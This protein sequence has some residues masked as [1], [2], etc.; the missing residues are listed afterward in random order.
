MRRYFAGMTEPV[1]KTLSTVAGVLVAKAFIFAGM[2]RAGTTQQ[3]VV[4]FQASS[5][6]KSRAGRENS[7][8]GSSTHCAPSFMGR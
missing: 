1:K 4:I 7:F 2:H 8:L 3:S 6:S 5:A